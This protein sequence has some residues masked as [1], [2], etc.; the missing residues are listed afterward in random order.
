MTRPPSR[1]TTSRSGRPK[2]AGTP[3]RSVRPRMRTD[4]AAAPGTLVVGAGHRLVAALQ[5]HLPD[6]S[7]V[8][9]EHPQL[10]R[11]P[12]VRDRLARLPVVGALLESSDLYGPD[13]AKVCA[14]L[15]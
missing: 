3:G 11:D 2:R 14:E 12:S 1:P 6:G 9:L 4:R 13:A 10:L 5:D 8:V 7:V 15:P